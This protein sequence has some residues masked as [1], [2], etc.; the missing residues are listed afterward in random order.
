MKISYYERD[1]KN[2][3]RAERIDD[4]G[5]TQVD[6]LEIELPAGLKKANTIVKV[7]FAVQKDSSLE[8]IAEVLTGDGKTISAEKIN[9]N[10]VSDLF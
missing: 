2:Y 8:F 7:T 9:V 3:P 4:D 10:K 5:I 1:L 6:E